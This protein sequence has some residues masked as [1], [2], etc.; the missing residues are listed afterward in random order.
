MGLVH[1]RLLIF[2][3][4]DDYCARRNPRYRLTDRVCYGRSIAIALPRRTS[5]TSRA[6]CPELCSTI[7]RIYLRGG[8]YYHIIPRYPSSTNV[9][10]TRMHMNPTPADIAEHRGRRFAVRNA[11]INGP[12]APPLSLLFLSSA[13]RHYS[14]K[15]ELWR[16]Q[17]LLLTYGV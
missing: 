5:R 8:R 11:T 6:L 7:I 17:A 13:R 3:L 1:S 10:E 16:Y 15:S 2:T 12:D 4:T 9:C 14:R